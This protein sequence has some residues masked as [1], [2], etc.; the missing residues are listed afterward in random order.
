MAH[1]EWR[2][3]HQ[4]RMFEVYLNIAEWDPMSMEQGKPLNSISQTAVATI[5]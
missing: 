5:G 1:R 4:D 3:N 2:T